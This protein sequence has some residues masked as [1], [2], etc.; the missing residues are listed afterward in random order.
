MIEIFDYEQ[1]TEEWFAARAGLPTASR[2][3]DILAEGKGLTRAKYMR[4][5]AA[6]IITGHV[7]EGYT[8]DHMQRGHDQE[9]EARRMFSLVADVVP[10]Q[11]GFVRNGPVG[12]SPDSLIG[13]DAGLEIKTA[14]GH[15][16]IARILKGGLPSEHK[17]QVQGSLWVTAR[18]RWSFVSYCPGLPLFITEVHRDEAYIGEL[19][20]AVGIFTDELQQ[21]V[22]TVRRY[23]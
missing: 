4:D 23:G 1:G 17:A 14:L 20:R 12:C 3:S 22:E 11:V 5:L 7:E 10:M 9:A 15:I 13:D 8:N 6:E 21:M 19:S 2:F 18:D 16:Q